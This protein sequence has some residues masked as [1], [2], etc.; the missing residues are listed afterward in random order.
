MYNL[1]V[2]Y[3]LILLCNHHHYVS[4]RHCYYPKLNWSF[5]LKLLNLRFLMKGWIFCL[6][7]LYFVPL[8]CLIQCQILI[9]LLYLCSL[10]ILACKSPILTL[11]QTSAGV[12]VALHSSEYI[13]KCLLSS[14]HSL[15][16]VNGSVSDISLRW[17]E[18]TSFSN[19]IHEYSHHPIFYIEFTI[20]SAW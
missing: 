13:L 2:S 4:P 11:C 5:K 10:Y 1:E 12:S 17:A 14:Q 19:F 16:Y 9:S 6:F 3:T 18:L 7:V 15:G 20:F 8:L